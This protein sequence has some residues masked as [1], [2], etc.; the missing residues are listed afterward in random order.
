MKVKTTA[1]GVT[2]GGEIKNVGDIIDLPEAA[3]EA[4]V[5]ANLADFADEDEAPQ[6]PLNLQ[7]MTVKQLQVIAAA[8]N[9]TGA[10]KMTKP[11]L[12]AAI[13]FELAE[14]GQG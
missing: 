13:E 4:L 8:K 10:D 1:P 11:K 14:G 5:D 2:F 9:I 7:K 6:E 12:I 3:A